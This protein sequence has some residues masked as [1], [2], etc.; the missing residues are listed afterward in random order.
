MSICDHESILVKQTSETSA[1]IHNMEYK[2]IGI[3]IE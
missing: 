3:T 1:M 2:F